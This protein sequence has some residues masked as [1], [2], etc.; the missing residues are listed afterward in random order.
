MAITR[1]AHMA[2]RCSDLEKS[3]DFY[4]N[5]IGFEFFAWRPQGD[6]IDITDGYINI[7]LLPYHGNRDGFEEGD[8]YI[9]FGVIVDN[10]QEIWDRAVQWGAEI[11]K[12]DVKDR[13][14]VELSEGPGRSFKVLDPDG[15]VIDVT[16]DRGEWRCVKFED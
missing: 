13:T 8:E 6:S 1:M 4:T 2:L 11:S 3:R 14:E 5:V 9:H 16:A 12:G 10:L 15:N 7:T